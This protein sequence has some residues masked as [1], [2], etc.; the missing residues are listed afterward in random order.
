MNENYTNM[1]SNEKNSKI[2]HKRQRT[3]NEDLSS[4]GDNWPRYLVMKQHLTQVVGMTLDKLSPF[5]A[6]KGI[7]SMAGP[8]KSVKRLRGGNLLVE[9]GKKSHSDNLLKIS[10]F[11]GCRVSVEP[12]KSLN[13]S[14]GVIRCR[15]FCS[16]SEEDILEELKPQDVINIR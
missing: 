6:D 5:A 7:R 13:F 15:A 8:P 4:N 2:P 1:G 16:M 14:K 3:G 11:V 10:T 12:H 9:F